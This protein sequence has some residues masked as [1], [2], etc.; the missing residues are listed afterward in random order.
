MATNSHAIALMSS[1]KAFAKLNETIRI[2]FSFSG[3]RPRR[4]SSLK[5]F[6]S[7]TRVGRL[8]FSEGEWLIDRP[9]IDH[10]PGGSKLWLERETP[11]RPLGGHPE[12]SKHDY[13]DEEQLAPEDSGR[14]HGQK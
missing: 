12:Q 5:V 3:A 7:S 14:G 4:C 13:R 8:N 6:A 10:E 9:A 11:G 2:D 1:R